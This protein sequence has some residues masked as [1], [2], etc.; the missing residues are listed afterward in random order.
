MGILNRETQNIQNAALGAMILW[1][2]TSGYQQG[3]RVSSPTPLPLLFIVLPVVLHQEMAQIIDSTQKR[4]GLRAFVKKF[5]D[6][7]VS[8]NDLVLTI[9][10]RSLKMRN[11]SMDS[12]RLAIWS[13]L[14]LID[15]TQG[16]VVPLSLTSPVAGIPD[17]IQLILKGAEKLG[18]W[19][20]EISLYEISIILK[21]G[22]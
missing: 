14:I 3:S 11:L 1:R 18:F 17:P 10:E 13:R 6:S 9:H 2:F 5:A 21:V 4:S 15:S 19:C 8:K 16:S 22:F 20:S 12:L 7:K